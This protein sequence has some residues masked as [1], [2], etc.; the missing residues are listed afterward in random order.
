MEE[1]QCSICG[2]LTFGYGDNPWPVRTGD[3]DRCC[4]DC[5]QRDV[6]PARIALLREEWAAD[7][8]GEAR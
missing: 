6:I 7:D 5:N 3:G 4:R 1:F 8:R 2:E